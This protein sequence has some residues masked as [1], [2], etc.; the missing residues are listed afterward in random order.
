M[1]G[2]IGKHQGQ[3]E[4]ESNGLPSTNRFFDFYLGSEIVPVP[5]QSRGGFMLFDI[6]NVSGTKPDNTQTN[7]LDTYGVESVP[8]LVGGWNEANQIGNRLFDETYLP[9]NATL[10]GWRYTSSSVLTPATRKYKFVITDPRIVE[11]ISIVPRTNN[12]GRTS[13]NN[14]GTGTLTLNLKGFENL[15]NVTLNEMWID[16]LNFNADSLSKIETIELTELLN[17][18]TLNGK[19][20]ASTKKFKIGSVTPLNN[21]NNFLSDAVNCEV[22]Q[23]GHWSPSPNFLNTYDALSGNLD[24]AHMTNLKELALGLVNLTGVTYPT[25]PANNWRIFFMWLCNAAVASTPDSIFNDALASSNLEFFGIHQSNRL[26]TKSFTNGDISPSLIGL[27]LY[28]NRITGDFTLTNSQ[29]LLKDLRLGISA[30]ELNRFANID[31]SGLN[32]GALTTLHLQGVECE[33]LTLPS[34]LSSLTTLF[35]YDNKLDIVT[36]SDLISK[37]N[38]YTNLLYLH[39]GD[40]GTSG[41]VSAN[42]LGANPDFSDLINLQQL[43][44]NHCKISG[45]LYLPDLTGLEAQPW[46]YLRQLVVRGNTG[47]TTIENFNGHATNISTL[48]IYDCSSLDIDLSVMKNVAFFTASNCGL[49]HLNLSGIT[50][51]AG[52][53]SFAINTSLNLERITF[54]TSEATCKFNNNVQFDSCP[55]LTAIT[56]HEY[57]N[58][59]ATNKGF[60]GDNCSLNITFQI[61]SNN[62]LP[63]NI[64]LQNNGMS[65]TNV[66][67]TLNNIYTNRAK[68]PVGSK[69]LNI[70]GTNSAPSGTFQAPTGFVLGSNDGTPASAKEEVYVLVNNYEWIITMN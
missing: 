37:I 14:N 22:I 45:S 67:N 31:L 16:T 56:N 58:Y 57:I 43:Y 69:T 36:N 70:G 46:L 10:R 32:G 35:A 59:G 29:T 33:D 5:S 17:L 62:F 21:I 28:G 60:F 39:L 40:A 24:I 48:N 20:P 26:W 47:L 18:S 50:S 64:L 49:T 25:V 11:V 12:Q 2:F 42:G 15:K 65:G 4:V 54:P 61:G 63:N 68:W 30:S 52:I 3:I 27:Y 23:F 44:L 8:L 55:S 13:T 41:Q 34:G 7:T 19:A 1:F 53:S 66:D 9:K 38:G 51:T 6:E